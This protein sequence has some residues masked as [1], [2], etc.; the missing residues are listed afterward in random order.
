MLKETSLCMGC[1]NEKD[2]DP[3]K[4]CGYSDL[5]PHIPTYLL[6]LIHI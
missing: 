2:G 3:C 1:M 5:D 6:S 4:I